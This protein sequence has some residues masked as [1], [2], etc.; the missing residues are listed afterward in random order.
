MY[1]KRIPKIIQEK[2]KARE[3][4][5]SWKKPNSN[6]SALTEGALKPTD[7]QSRTTFV[8]MCSNK[9]DSVTNILISG[10]KHNPDANTSRPSGRTMRHGLDVEGDYGSD[11]NTFLYQQTLRNGIRPIAGIKDINVEYKGLTKL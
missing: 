8:R 11:F 1:V 10:G 2:L 6:Q 4:A 5:L 3:R 7:I 9:V